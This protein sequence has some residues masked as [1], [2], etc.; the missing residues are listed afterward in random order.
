[1]IASQLLSIAE[2]CRRLDARRLLQSP[3]RRLL[4]AVGRLQRRHR[5]LPYLNEHL[6]RDIGI[7]PPPKPREQIWP[8]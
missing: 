4:G 2:F 6:C 1:M 7:E 3:L 8:R 5:R